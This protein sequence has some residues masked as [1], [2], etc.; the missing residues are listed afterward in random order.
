MFREAFCSMYK[1]QTLRVKY[2]MRFAALGSIVLIIATVLSFTGFVLTEIVLIMFLANT[3][4]VFPGWIVKD[5]D[6]DFSE[7]RCSGGFRNYWTNRNLLY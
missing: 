4:L 2:L 7:V 5:S 1:R 6:Q 3:S